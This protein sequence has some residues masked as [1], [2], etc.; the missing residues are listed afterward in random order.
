MGPLGGPQ[1]IP[2]G[3]LEGPNRSSMGTKSNVGLLKN[4][5]QGCVNLYEAYYQIK[6]LKRFSWSKFMGGGVVGIAIPLGEGAP[7]W[8]VVTGPPNPDYGP[9]RATTVSNL[10]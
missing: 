6:N 1:W 2:N 7:R 10:S 3:A 4:T 5:R 9:A 8:Q